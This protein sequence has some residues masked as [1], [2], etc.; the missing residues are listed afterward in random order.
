MCALQAVGVGE[1]Q[2]EKDGD[3]KMNAQGQRSKEYYC[4][5]QISLPKP[6][7]EIEYPVRHGL[8]AFGSV[9][10]LAVSHEV[11][12]WSLLGHRL[13]PKSAVRGKATWSVAR[14]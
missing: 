11:L 7:L 14:R 10:F 6:H 4:G 8:G 3:V 1:S 12:D 2:D 9:V 13:N 5:Q